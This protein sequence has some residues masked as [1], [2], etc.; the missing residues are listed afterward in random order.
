MYIIIGGASM[1]GAGLANLL[2]EHKHNVVLIEI[3]QQTAERVAAQFGS[4]VVVHGSATDIQILEEAGIE[5]ADAV[6]AVMGRDADNM[7]MSLLARNYQVPRIVARMRDPRYEQAYRCAGVHNVVRVMDYLIDQM[8]TIIED[9]PVQKVFGLAGR[10]AEI[11]LVRI[12]RK[13]RVSG[14]SVRNISQLPNFPDECLIT[15]IVSGESGALVIPRGDRIVQG[16]DSVFLVVHT[17]DLDRAATCL[18]RERLL[19]RRVSSTATPPADEGHPL[20][21]GDEDR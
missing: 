12:P 3:D 20:G 17:K 8:V 18:T 14:M 15:G 10:G 5:K 1:V 11:H 9:P 4:V 6:C 21:A 16:G 2:A 13:A 19:G 7:A